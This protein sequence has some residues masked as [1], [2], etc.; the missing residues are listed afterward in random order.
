MTKYIALLRG[1]NVGG[2]R[3]VLMAD[4]KALFEKLGFTNITTYIQTGNVI[5]ESK[6]SED[7]LTLAQCIQN[8]ILETYQFEVPVMIRS[9]S[10]WEQA[11]SD[12][13][14]FKDKS[15]AIGRLHLTLLDESPEADRLAFLKKMDFGFDQFEIIG[16]HV[17]ICC[18]EKYSDTKLTNGLFEKKLKCKA[19]TRNW[20]TVLKLSELSQ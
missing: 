4:M 20:K 10:E 15:I 18:A 16:K 11:I 5:F 6:K 3:K 12:N 9:L 13:P 2:K 1:I 17:F 8:A 14:F 7:N 19:T